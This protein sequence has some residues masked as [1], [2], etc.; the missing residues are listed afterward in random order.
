MSSFTDPL[1][2][3]LVREGGGR[4]FELL[5]SFSY[6][7]KIGG[8]KV[9]FIPSGFVTDFASVPRI[10]WSI[11][12]PV[13]HHTKASVVHDYLYCKDCKYKV[14]RYEAD[15]IFLEAMKVTKTSLFTRTLYYAAVRLFGSLFFRKTKNST[16]NFNY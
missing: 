9:I 5:Q 14:T 13:G 12:P 10:F 2:L 6:Y 4:R 8:Y 16:S 7:T 11:A 1:K 3:K 15:R